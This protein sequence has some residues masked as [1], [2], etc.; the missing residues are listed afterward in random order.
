MLP[1]PK[2]FN[3]KLAKYTKT[4]DNEDLQKMVQM[5]LYKNPKQFQV[6]TNETDTDTFNPTEK[7]V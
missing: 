6:P 7:S 5:L 2:D 3:I 4:A 1:K